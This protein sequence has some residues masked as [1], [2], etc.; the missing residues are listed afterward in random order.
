[1]HQHRLTATFC[2][3]FSL[4]RHATSSRRSGTICDV[5]ACGMRGIRQRAPVERAPSGQRSPKHTLS[6]PGNAATCA[7][8]GTRTENDVLLTLR[9]TRTS[10]FF[11]PFV[12]I[13]F[14]FWQI[15]RFFTRVLLFLLIF[16]GVSAF[17]WVR[18]SRMWVLEVRDCIGRMATMRFQRHQMSVVPVSIVVKARC[19]TQQH[20]PQS[21]T[22]AQT[23]DR[24]RAQGTPA[25]EV[26]EWRD[27]IDFS[28]TPQ[29]SCWLPSTLSIDCSSLWALL[30]RL[31]PG[32]D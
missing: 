32:D 7:E 19:R 27:D 1:M 6:V 28:L 11:S 3:P 2:I 31:G 29:P 24:R 5:V 15:V 21:A 30:W 25:P 14:L 10:I 13:V 23:H 26:P 22:A 4:G 12:L 17:L 8:P 18:R 20:A 16:S 9:G